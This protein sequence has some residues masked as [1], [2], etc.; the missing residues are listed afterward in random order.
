MK[1]EGNFQQLYGQQES[2]SIACFT[3]DMLHQHSQ[4]NSNLTSRRSFATHV[5]Y[6]KLHSIYYTHCT[7]RAWLLALSWTTL[8]QL[9]VSV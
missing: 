4:L 7:F 5:K 8:M 6:A 3:N 2:N 9:A 1:L